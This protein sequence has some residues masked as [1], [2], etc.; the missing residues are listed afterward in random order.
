MNHNIPK[1]AFSF[2]EG[3]E[4]TYLNYLTI[5][6]FAKYNPDYRIIIYTTNDT[7]ICDKTMFQ[8]VVKY[9]NLYDFNELRKIPNVEVQVVNIKD[10]INYDGVLTPVWKSD[11]IR[12]W[13]LYEHGGIY[14]DFDILNYI[15]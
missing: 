5:F 8:S 4:F 14:L 12:I 3:P 9:H 15:K 2:W 6:S 11:I 10:L 7:P 1:I 13:K